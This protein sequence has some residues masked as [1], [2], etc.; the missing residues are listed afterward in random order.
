MEEIQTR[1][2]IIKTYD[3]R[4]V[5]IPNADLFTHSVIVNT[6][7]DIRRWEYDFTVKGNFALVEVK[8]RVVDAVR[9][10]PGTL[11][12]PSPEVLVLELG[13][14]E[15]NALKLRVL[16]WTKA[17]RQHQML[18]SYDGVLTAIRQTLHQYTAEQ[19]RKSNRAA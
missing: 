12:E 9:K 10:V 1:A 5:V 15:S 16:W 2:T 6:A 4:R 11:S 3:E 18:T 17:P 7:A 8:S 14:L 13:E 19:N